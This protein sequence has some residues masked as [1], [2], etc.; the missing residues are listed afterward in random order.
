MF[1]YDIGGNVVEVATNEALTQLPFNKSLIA[2]KLTQKDPER[3]EVIGGLKTLEAVFK[4]FQPSCEVE[5]T[6]EDGSTTKETLKFSQM[7]DFEI[8][9]MTN[10]SRFLNDI[11]FV[12]DF[13][14]TILKQLRQN[15]QLAKVLENPETKSA[16]IDV[17]K[18]LAS[19]L[20]STK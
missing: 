11:D 16:F 4:H 9:S 6:K 7:K 3:P 12:R 18:S 14:L 1:N 2:L 13:Q 15:K 5:F 20:E 8:K 19:K 10:Q 17:L